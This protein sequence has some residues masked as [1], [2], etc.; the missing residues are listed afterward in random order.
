MAYRD[1]DSKLRYAISIADFILEDNGHTVLAASKEF[2]VSRTTIERNII[3]LGS[4]AFYGNEPNAKDLKLKYKAVKD[5]LD[6][7]TTENRPDNISKYNS[8]RAASK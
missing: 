4:I 8:K 6:R 7:L 2:G 3:F 1:H 5:T